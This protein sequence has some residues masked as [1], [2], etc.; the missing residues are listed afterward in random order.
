MSWSHSDSRNRLRPA[1]RTS[2]L[3]A[4]LQLAT[5]AR[6]RAENRVEYRYEDYIEDNDRIRIRTHSVY[7]EQALNSKVTVK[8]NFVY[9]GISGASPSGGIPA[10]G[11]DQVPLQQLEDIRRA[12]YLEGAITTGRFITRP[13][14]SYSVESDY[15]SIGLSL[16]ES[17]E[18]NQKNTVLTVGLAR[19]FDRVTGYW[20]SNKT[21]W[22]HKDTWDAL[23]GVTQL[24]GPKTYLTANFTV[25]VSDGYL[26][27]PYKGVYFRYDYPGDDLN[28]DPSFP[29]PERRP[30]QRIKEIAYLGITHFV[31]RLNGSIDANYRFHNDDWGIQAHTFTATWNQKVGNRVTISPLFR[32]HRQSAADFYAPVFTGS[33]NRADANGVQ[34]ALQSDGSYLF[35]GDPG[36]PGDGTPF[37]VPAW[38]KYF[39]S[40]Y[41]LSELETFTAGVEI[42]WEV[43]DHVSV[44]LGY[45]RY[46]MFGLDSNSYRSSYPQ[47]HV[48][49]VGMG[50]R[51]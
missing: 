16:N 34:V 35:D 3:A 25:S 32:Y 30:D 4:L 11:S 13:Q 14:V 51:W 17:I 43:S 9:D 46:A 5:P 8:G 15:E 12:G 37:Q 20:L 24:L 38:P 47:A 10:A 27:D 19:N 22:K 18:F 26:T 42:R 33:N 7:A 40:D 6:G 28:T 21:V 1:L 49:T 45:K 41:R 48:F 50:F 29:I 2:V 44:D 36:Y 23:I 31:T 39:S